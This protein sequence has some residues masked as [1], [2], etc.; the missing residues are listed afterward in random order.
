MHSALDM[1]IE[2]V[3]PKE[4]LL[5]RF[6]MLFIDKFTQLNPGRS[7]C[8]TW[9]LTGD[10]WFFSGHF[11]GRPVVPG[12]LVVEAIAQVAAV[13]MLSHERGERRMWMLA[14][15]DNCRFRHVVVPGD[16]LESKLE[17]TH[18][19]AKSSKAIGEASVGN[20]LACHV[21]LLFVFPKDRS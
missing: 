14:G 18:F 17:L 11:P 6:P 8:A 7:A 9:H 21:E 19:S 12:A 5:N 15:I 20:E 10:E 3:D 2:E 1:P 4:I 16:T 13:V